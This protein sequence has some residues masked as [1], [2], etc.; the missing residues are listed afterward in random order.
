MSTLEEAPRQV[1]KVWVARQ[2]AG[3]VVVQD[4]DYQN[5]SG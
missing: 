4:T 5:C 3:I 1:M 2:H